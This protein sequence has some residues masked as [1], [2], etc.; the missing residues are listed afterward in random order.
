MKTAAINKFFHLPCIDFWA[1]VEMKS[2]DVNKYSKLFKSKITAFS[3]CEF[4][5]Y[6]HSDVAVKPQKSM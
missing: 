4:C 5:S 3:S 1:G 6:V 2:F